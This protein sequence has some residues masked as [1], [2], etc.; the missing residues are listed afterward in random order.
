MGLWSALKWQ[1]GSRRHRAW[2]K[3]PSRGISCGRWE[4]REK[5]YHPLGLRAAARVPAGLKIPQ[6]QIAETYGK[7]CCAELS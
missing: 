3:G 4:K 7:C 5:Y 6:E 2:P 1:S